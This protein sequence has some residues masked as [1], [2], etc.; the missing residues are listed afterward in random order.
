[1][2]VMMFM[3]LAFTEGRATTLGCLGSG[4]HIYS[5]TYEKESNLLLSLFNHN[6]VSKMLWSADTE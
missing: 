2:S 5:E 4:Q 3:S 6:H 1:M